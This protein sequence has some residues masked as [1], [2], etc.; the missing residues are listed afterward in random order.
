MNDNTIAW[1]KELREGGHKEKTYPRP[2]S[3]GTELGPIEVG[4]ILFFKAFDIPLS[5]ENNLNPLNSELQKA[6]YTYKDIYAWL[7]VS[8]L[9]GGIVNGLLWKENK[10]FRQ[11]ADY[12]EKNP[13][14]VFKN[15]VESK[16][17]LVPAKVASL[18]C[19]L[20]AL[21][22]TDISKIE[23]GKAPE[24]DS[25]YQGLAFVDLQDV[26]GLI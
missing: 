20:G 24:K 14:E 7:G 19:Q 15:P 1:I 23:A 25:P 26:T 8:Y 2:Y 13:R 9:G 17:D 11:I 22:F 6:G 12:L 5:G 18:K 21:P 10:N 4:A 3:L 16:L